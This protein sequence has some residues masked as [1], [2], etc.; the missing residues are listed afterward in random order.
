MN[1][2]ALSNVVFA[3]GGDQDRFGGNFGHL[4]RSQPDEAS[5][6]A[7]SEQVNN[8]KAPLSQQEE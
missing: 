3:Q 6:A 2:L 7:A 5:E 1:V 4:E 8:A